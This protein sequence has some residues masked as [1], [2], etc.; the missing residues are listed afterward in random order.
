MAGN[1]ASS[2]YKAARSMGRK[3]L[4]DHAKNDFKGYL[5]VLDDRVRD[6]DLVGEV[7][8]GLREI[9]ISKIIG[10]RT[11]ARSNAFA[12]NFMPLLAENTEFGAKWCKLYASHIEEGIREPIKVYEYINRYFVQEG[13]KRVSVLRYCGAVSAYAKVTRIIPRRDESNHAVCIYYEFLDFDRREV[14]DNLWFSHEGTFTSIVE[15][16]RAWC[17]AR[18]GKGDNRTVADAMRSDYADFR[19]VYKAAGF[20]S[21]PITTGDAYGQYLDIYGFSPD[22]GA[23][24]LQTRVKSCEVQFKLLSLTALGETA[25]N[26]V[27][28]KPNAEKAPLGLFSKRRQ[29]LRVAFAFESTPEK[30][31]WT[32]THD[33]ARRRLEQKLGSKIEVVTRYD[34]PVGDACYQVIDELLDT[35]PDLLFATSPNMSGCLLRLSLEHPET[36]ILCCDGAKPNHNVMTYFPRLHEAAWLTGILAG[37]MTCT[38][39][40]GYMT[41]ARFHRDNTQN[42]NAF[43]L[44]AQ[45]VN[46]R[47]QIINYRMARANA[48][49]I[50]H[51]TARREMAMRGADMAFCQHQMNTPLVRK[52]FP[53]VWA[54][55]YMLDLRTGHPKEAIGALALDWSV[56]Y[57]QMVEDCFNTKSSI[58]DI[59]HSGEDASL[60][61]G[62]GID[63]GLFDVYG[64]DAFMGH[65]ATRLMKIFREMLIGGRI[66]PFEGPVV[67]RDRNIRLDKGDTMDL[68]EIQNMTWYHEAV[69]E[70]I[71]GK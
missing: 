49:E 12:G 29:S 17:I 38:D 35:K 44:G 43:A 31:L 52:G 4:S 53:G 27:E 69:V 13:N 56:V 66:R 63:T 55:L 25:V 47:V 37:S 9:P 60:H 24:L 61:F 16:V 5:P 36:A 30:S 1:E 8:L 14:F 40:V 59:S 67:D 22:C 10:T 20:A 11:N 70:V 65:N 39:V 19:R 15:R 58:L 64:V 2:A 21:I 71:E 28:M 23:E 33:L 57:T 50:D 7:N 41:P 46:P 51:I 18:D 6:S 3:F 54:Q 45:L 26:A 62:W 42:L 34:V 68:L 32:N 48:P